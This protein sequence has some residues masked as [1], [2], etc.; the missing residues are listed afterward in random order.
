MEAVCGCCGV[1]ALT[2]MYGGRRLCA[3]CYDFLGPMPKPPRG[4]IDPPKE[5]TTPAQDNAIRVMEDQE[6]T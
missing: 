4:G 5:D 6:T 3:F 1:L 2:A